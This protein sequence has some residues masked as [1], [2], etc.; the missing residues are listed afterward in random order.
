MAAKRVAQVDRRRCV[1]CGACVGE[2]PRGALRV[3][4]GCFAIVD[5][6][7]CV[8]CGKCSRVCPADCITL[9]PREETA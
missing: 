1:S 5:P 2:C 4:R 3:W 9:K 6:A 7:A 8:G